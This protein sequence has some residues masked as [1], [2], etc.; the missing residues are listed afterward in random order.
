[1][2]FAGE[3]TRRL[4]MAQTVGHTEELSN[5]VRET[6]LQSEMIRLYLYIYKMICVGRLLCACIVGTLAL[7]LN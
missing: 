6:S 1:M 2:L 7:K 5:P 3:G 4:V